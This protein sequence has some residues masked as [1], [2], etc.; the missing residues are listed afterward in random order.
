ML[1]FLVVCICT[2]QDYVWCSFPWPDLILIPTHKLTSQPVL[3]RSPSPRRWPIPRTGAAPVS[4]GCPA[5]WLGWW[6]GLWIVRSCPATPGD[7]LHL[8]ASSPQGIASPHS[9]LAITGV[10]MQLCLFLSQ[11]VVFVQTCFPWV[12]YCTIVCIAHISAYDLSQSYERNHLHFYMLHFMP[13]GI[14]KWKIVFCWNHV[15]YSFYLF[16][17]Y[18]HMNM[19]ILSYF[20]IRL[21][22]ILSY[23]IWS[24]TL[25]ELWN[26]RREEINDKKPNKW[27]C[28]I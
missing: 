8:L 12:W 6:N 26:L 5:P 20:P 18:T 3:G 14:W 17:I 23:F 11:H 25:R 16:Y 19:N 10:K 4:H 28:G 9:V 27:N 15:F 1:I 7:T 22:D 24:S 21:W 2:Y 13:S